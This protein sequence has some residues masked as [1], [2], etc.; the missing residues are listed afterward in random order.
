MGVWTECNPRG[1]DILSEA[2]P[3]ILSEARLVILSEAEGST[4]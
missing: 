3:V 1:F 2:S 4:R